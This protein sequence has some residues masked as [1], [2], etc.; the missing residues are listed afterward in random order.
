MS[1]ARGLWLTVIVGLV[2]GVPVPAAET[3]HPLL[4]DYQDL[5]EWA[6]SS[7][8]VDLDTAGLHWQIDVGEWHLDS[9]RIWLQR[10]TSAGELTGLVFEGSGRYSI[11]IPD[12]KELRQL[13]RFTGDPELR[14]LEGSF[15]ALVVRGINMAPL[16]QMPKPAANTRYSANSLA[17]HRHQHWLALR[18]FDVDARLVAALGRRD[19][20][21]TRVDMKTKEHGWLTFDYEPR[22]AEEIVVEWFNPAFSVLES[23]LSLDRQADRLED[24]RPTAEPRP[25]LDIVHMVIAADLTTLASES[26][27]GIAKVRPVDAQIEVEILFD[28]LRDG[29]QTVQLFL[30]PWAKIQSVQDESSQDL[31]F[32]R[33]HL[34]KRSSAIDKKVYDDSLVVLLKEP[35]IR[36]RQTTLSLTYE[37]EMSGYAPGRSWYPSA[38][39]PGTGIY[40]QHTASLTLQQRPKYASRSMGKLSSESPRDST[41]TTVWQ[42]EEPVKML[43]FVFARQHYEESFPTSGPTTVSAFSSLGGFISRQRVQELGE[44]AAQIIDFY[45]DL[46]GSPMAPTDLVV[47]LIP[48]THGQA[49]DGLIHIGDFSTISDRVA[50]REMFRAHEVAHLW[51]GH[52]VGWHGYRDQWLSEGFAEYSAMMFVEARVDN[53]EKF[54]DEMLKTFAHELT[55]SIESDFSQFSRPGFSLLN[56]RAGDRVGP[57]GHGRRCRVGE[58]PSAYLSQTYKKGAMVLNSLRVILRA[59]TGSDVMF[60]EILRDFVDT[61]RGGFPTTEDFQKLVETATEE[62]WTWFFDS[63]IYTAEI[64]TYEWGFD[65]TSTPEG[66]LLTLQIERRNVHPGF[67]MAIPVRV[68]L[69]DGDERMLLAFMDQKEK[70]FQFPLPASPKR[71]VFNPDN[72]VL[73]RVKKR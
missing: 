28:P 58:A 9:G 16:D 70:T 26:Q 5:Q 36:G 43:S 21:Y 14:Q 45:E 65:A 49:F 32:A 56:K 7:A 4:A 23:W 2:G 37:M 25:A 6:F 19:D 10:P 57:I 60:L 34:G 15:D 24:G 64:P 11:A 12:P 35:L 66:T 29:D 1:V 55:G 18:G 13:R 50:E 38:T 39:Y 22:R 40:D 54:F 33:D 61:Q 46:F 72:A 47:S 71:V 51:W 30:H 52:Q 73:A 63:W 8:P 20:A 44:D 53:G 62:D 31:D 42:M 68:D 3:P 27:R 41:T 69:E 17:K 67:S 48:A 59:K